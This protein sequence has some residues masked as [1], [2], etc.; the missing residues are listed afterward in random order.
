[1]ARGQGRVR[2]MTVAVSVVDA[3]KVVK[4]LPPNIETIR[5]F[6]D[7]RP[8]MWFTY[9][10]TIFG[11]ERVAPPDVIEHERVHMAQQAKLGVAPCMKRCTDGRL[12]RQ[13]HAAS[14]DLILGAERWWERYRNPDFRLQQEV[15]AYRAHLRFLYPRISPSSRPGAKVAI[16]QALL[17]PS[18]GLRINESTALRL[19]S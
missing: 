11:P 14:A 5:T 8:Q 13:Y 15:E 6:L 2:A 16:A 3:M 10:N 17:N 7:P 4:G 1:M 18:Y 9:G 19:L 12:C